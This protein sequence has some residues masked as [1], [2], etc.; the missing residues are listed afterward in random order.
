MCRKWGRE[1]WRGQGGG[2]RRRDYI[3]FLR[4]NTLY[5]LFH[6]KGEAKQSF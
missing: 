4:D 2:H 5:F 6:K 3:F 1:R